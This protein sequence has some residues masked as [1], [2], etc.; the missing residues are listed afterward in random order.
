VKYNNLPVG[1]F[2]NNPLPYFITITNLQHNYINYKSGYYPITLKPYR[3]NLS[4]HFHIGTY[5]PLTHDWITFDLKPMFLHSL[6]LLSTGP[7]L[8]FI[9]A[10]F[11][12]PM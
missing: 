9:R 1:W 7:A 3:L 4:T 11:T 8:T 5:L 10:F 6:F 2:H 12:S